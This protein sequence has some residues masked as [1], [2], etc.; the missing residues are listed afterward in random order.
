MVHPKEEKDDNDPT[1]STGI[2][3]QGYNTPL[4]VQSRNAQEG[5]EEESGE[6][7]EI[8]E[9]EEEDVEEVE[10]KD[11]RAASIKASN[12]CPQRVTGVTNSQKTK[13]VHL[14]QY[15]FT[16][17]RGVGYSRF[18]NVGLIL[19]VDMTIRIVDRVMFFIRVGYLAK[20][21]FDIT[22]PFNY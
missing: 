19:T 18:F 22:D 10:G 2:E 21:F 16:F 4:N 11:A 17:F 5:N 14:A 8:Q 6:E 7:D 12:I 1:E 3:P 9:E 13:R 20:T 15:S